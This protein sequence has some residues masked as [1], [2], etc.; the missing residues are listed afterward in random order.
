MWLDRVRIHLENILH[1]SNKENEMLI[2]MAN[3]YITR[4]NICNIKLKQLKDK[5]KKTLIKQKE[6]DKIEI[7]TSAS[8]I[9]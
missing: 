8:L 6:E 3:R 9:D 1:D 7:L 5:Y 4:N 2:H